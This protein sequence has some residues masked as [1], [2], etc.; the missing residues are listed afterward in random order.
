M[1]RQADRLICAWIG[2][3]MWR[4]SLVLLLPIIVLGVALGVGNS[5]IR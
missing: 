1:I 2:E 3:S 4:A 5:L